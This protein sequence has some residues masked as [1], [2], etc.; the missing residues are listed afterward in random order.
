MLR[1]FTL[2]NHLQIQ[3][4]LQKDTTSILTWFRI[5]LNLCGNYSQPAMYVYCPH[6][7]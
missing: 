4:I 5:V 7:C 6:V 3:L 1:Y 2:V